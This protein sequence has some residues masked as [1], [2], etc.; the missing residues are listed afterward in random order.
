MVIADRAVEGGVVLK[1]SPVIG[2][3]HISPHAVSVTVLARR[4]K[5]PTRYGL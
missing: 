2:R 1:V 4:Q 3:L 5:F